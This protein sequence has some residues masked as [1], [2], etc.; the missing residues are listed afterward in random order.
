[1]PDKTSVLI[2]GAG[3]V[4]LSLAHGL[5]RQGV[6]VAVVEQAPVT[7]EHS[8]A[9][10]ILP[11]TLEIFRAWNLLEA[12]LEEGQFLR[13]IKP[14]VVGEAHTATRRML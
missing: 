7:S 14:R 5:I 9:I 8:K 10:A 1:M 2:A 11:A 6:D 4:G 3:P 12:F 13:Q